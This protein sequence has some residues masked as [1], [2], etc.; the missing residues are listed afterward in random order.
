MS[1]Q[2]QHRLC[3]LDSSSLQVLLCPKQEDGSVAVPRRAALLYAL[4]NCK[5]KKASV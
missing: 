1:R 4:G 2:L 5:V 3:P